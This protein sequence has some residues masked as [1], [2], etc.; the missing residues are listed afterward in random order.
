MF[1]R[2]SQNFLAALSIR[3][4]CKDDSRALL[5]KNSNISKNWLPIL[6][7]VLGHADLAEQ[8]FTPDF[9]TRPIATLAATLPGLHCAT[10]GRWGT[11]P[12]VKWICIFQQQQQQEEEEQQGHGKEQQQQQEGQCQQQQKPPLPQPPPP[13]CQCASIDE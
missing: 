5:K 13:R 6:L 12:P 10:E 7:S 4:R 1:V 11:S 8:A 9:S 3:A 2:I